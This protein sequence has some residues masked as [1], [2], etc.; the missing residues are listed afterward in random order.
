MAARRRRGDTCRAIHATA[1]RLA[2]LYALVIAPPPPRNGDDVGTLP[3]T[4]ATFAGVTEE[5]NQRCGICPF[6]GKEK[7]GFMEPRV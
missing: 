7:G 1:A 4:V 2:V 5:I 6:P 3:E